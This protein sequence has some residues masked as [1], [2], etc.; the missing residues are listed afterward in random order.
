VPLGRLD[1]EPRGNLIN[2]VA[3]IEPGIL[4]GQYELPR[5]SYSD[6]EE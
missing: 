1:L 3:R 5:E 6:A 4:S 2:V